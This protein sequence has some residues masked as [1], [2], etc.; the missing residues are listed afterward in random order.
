MATVADVLDAVRAAEAAGASPAV[1]LDAALSAA[2]R[3]PAATA[4]RPAPPATAYRARDGDVLDA[5]AAALYGDEY[6]VHDVLAANSA[7]APHPPHLAA[8]TLVGLPPV[9]PH[10][11]E[12]RAVQLW[13]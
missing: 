9:T 6:A 4:A 12:R 8:G 1:V 3:G 7:L 2:A 11:P 13:D 10:P 5:V